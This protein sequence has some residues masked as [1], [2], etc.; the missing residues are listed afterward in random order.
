MALIKEVR[1][2]RPHIGDNCYLAENAVI[3]G[4]VVLGEN[5]S[6]WFHAVVRG[7]VTK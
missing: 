1:G 4:D 7:D 5:C 2:F 6:V 3:I